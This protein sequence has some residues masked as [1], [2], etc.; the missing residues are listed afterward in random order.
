MS[1]AESDVVTLEVTILGSVHIGRCGRG[2]VLV[3]GVDFFFWQGG[4]GAREHG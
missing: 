3:G 2:S 1:I 4:K